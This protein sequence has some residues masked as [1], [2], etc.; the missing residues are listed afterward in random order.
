MTAPS[1]MFASESRLFRDQH[2]RSWESAVTM[3]SKQ[4]GERGLMYDR[5]GYLTPVD[6]DAPWMLP[7]EY[8]TTVA[9]T[10]FGDEVFMDYDRYIADT[11]QAYT[12]WEQQVRRL[13]QKAFG[14]EYHPGMAPTPGVI[15]DAG[16]APR[17]WQP[18]DAARK[19]NRW[20]LYGEGEMPSKLAPFF[21]VADP[22][23]D[24]DLS[25]EDEPP[26]RGNAAAVV[27]AAEEDADREALM[28]A[29]RAARQKAQRPAAVSVDEEA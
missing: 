24:D 18:A 11:R 10:R 23:L 3:L 20:I 17:A 5:I 21:T 4:P 19:G 25:W 15:A 22:T 1:F 2:G 28:L 9:G 27:E 26:A 8:I 14:T 13:M 7:H 16:P 6:H 12:E 29:K